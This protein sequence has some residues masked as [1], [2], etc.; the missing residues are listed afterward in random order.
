MLMKRSLSMT[1]LV[2][3][4]CLAAQTAAWGGQVPGAAG[5]RDIPVS[6]R[7]RPCSPLSGPADLLDE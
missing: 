4:T 3:G 2:V 1:A 5:D 7:D 6:H